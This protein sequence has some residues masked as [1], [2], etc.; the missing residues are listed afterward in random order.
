[1]KK[2]AKQM[3]NGLTRAGQIDLFVPEFTFS[4]SKFERSKF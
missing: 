4:N 2:S 3:K 1:M